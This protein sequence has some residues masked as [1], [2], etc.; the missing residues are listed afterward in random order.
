[1]HFLF[2]LSFRAFCS[3]EVY[4]FRIVEFVDFAFRMLTDRSPHHGHEHIC[5]NLVRKFV[6][7]Y[8]SQLEFIFVHCVY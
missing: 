8:F 5:L 6:K 1:M 3:P 4:N 2:T 7:L